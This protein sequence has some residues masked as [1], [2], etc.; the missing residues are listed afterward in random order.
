MF[1]FN[2]LG[3]HAGLLFLSASVLARWCKGGKRALNHLKTTC[4]D[5]NNIFAKI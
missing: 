4:K 2:L 3:K 1:S 5:S